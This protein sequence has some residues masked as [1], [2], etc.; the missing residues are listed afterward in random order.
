M[1]PISARAPNNRVRGFF[2]AWAGIALDGMDSFIPP[3]VVVPAM[4]ELL[5]AS[6]ISVTT[7]SLRAW[8][9]IMFSA[10]LIGWGSA[11]LRGPLADRFGRVRTLIYAILCY[12]LFTFLGS[13]REMFGNSL[14]SVCSRV[15]ALEASSSAQPYSRWKNL[16]TTRARSGRVS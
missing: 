10:F 7:A 16:V 8:G 3:L 6:G 2:A 13:V 14:L 12:S 9:S 15:L 5:P 4:R 1:T 11:F